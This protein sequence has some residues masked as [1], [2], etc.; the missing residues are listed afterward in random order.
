MGVLQP[1]L[2][3]EPRELPCTS[4]NLLVLMETGR[5]T[6]SYFTVRELET[7]KGTITQVGKLGPKVLDR[8]RGGV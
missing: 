7:Q 5:N 6:G 4:N 8:V 1:G 3:K 2:I